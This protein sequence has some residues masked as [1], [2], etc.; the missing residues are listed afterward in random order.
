MG[1]HDYAYSVLLAGDGGGGGSDGCHKDRDFTDPRSGT[2]DLVTQLALSTAMGMSAFL[3]FCVLRQKWTGLYGARKKQMKQAAILPE[4]PESLFG[5]IPALYKIGDEEVL[6]AAGLDAYV[7]LGFFKMSMKMVSVFTFFGLVVMTPIHW[8]YEGKSGFDFHLPGYTNDT[9]GDKPMHT[10]GLD[11]FSDD[12]KPKPEVPTHTAWLTSYLVFVYFFTGVAL[13]YLYEQTQKVVDV[14]QKY[15]G[16]QSTITDRTIRLSGIPGHLRHE[17]QLKKFM[18]GLRIGKVENVTVCRDWNE[19]DK[20]MS[21]RMGTLRQLEEAWTVFQGG[22]RVERSQATLPFVQPAP[23]SPLPNEQGDQESQPLLAG[24]NEDTPYGRKRPTI[25]KRSGW[26]SRGE[27]VDAIEHFTSL[28]EELD[29]SIMETRQKE[30]K[31]VPMAFVTM[32]SVAAA[33]MAVQALLDPNPLSLIANLAPAPHDIVWQNTYISRRQR[34]VRMWI[35]TIF[36]GILTIC[37]LFPVG[38]LAGLLNIKSIRRVW[39]WLADALASNSVVSSLVQNTLPTIVLTLLNV[40]VPYIYDWLSNMQGMISQ[41]DVERSVISKNFFFTFFNLFLVFTVFGTVSDMYNV[42]KDSLKDS[43]TIAYRL[44][45]SLGSFAPFYTNLIMLQGIGM[46]PFRLLEFGSVAL[47]PISLMG[48]KTPRDFAQL[49]SP[50]VFQYGF[51]LPQP[52]L[53][54]ILCLVYSLLPSGTVML[55]FGLIYFSFGYFTYK[56]QLLYA[57]DHPRHATGKSW[58]MI[59]YRIFVGLLLFQGSMAALL[60]LQGAI[61][62][63]ILIFPLIGATTWAWWFFQKSFSPLM[64]YIALRSLHDPDPRNRS[65][66]RDGSGSGGG[67]EYDRETV[68][69]SR[70]MGSKFVNPNLVSELQGVWLHAERH[71]AELAL[72]AALEAGFPISTGILPVRR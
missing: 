37:W 66:S 1:I 22:R 54:L 20:M 16:R 47:Y 27:K 44:A 19:L 12:E 31:P 45:S 39:P 30:F 28:L 40:A 64:S 11:G 5:W 24:G 35:I 2:Q 41:A 4:L 71:V 9:C 50:P 43:T 57:M 7:F 46:F 58:P 23:P 15:L 59:C 3:S 53:V 13:Y 14:R 6:H 25:T 60:S 62:R 69:E 49:V 56:Y 55:G 10:W 63:G 36:I 67:V 26:F 32:D 52:I 38:T 8:K 18:E 21:K 65:R 29:G 70:E 68:D 48:S 17:D 33:Q 72:P 34:I 61:I 42:L 51:Y